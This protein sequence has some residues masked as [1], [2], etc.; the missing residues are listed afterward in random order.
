[1]TSICFVLLIIFLVFPVPAYS[2][3]PRYYSCSGNQPNSIVDIQFDAS[4]RFESVVT[5]TTSHEHRLIWYLYSTPMRISMKALVDS[6]GDSR[7]QV[8]GFRSP[9]NVSNVTC[10]PAGNDVFYWQVISFFIGA[11]A[12]MA[13]VM[14]ATHRWW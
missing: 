5:F 10:S 13:F 7:V 4:S 8:L 12:T 9:V 11:V 2:A 6:K 14:A 3:I 1:M